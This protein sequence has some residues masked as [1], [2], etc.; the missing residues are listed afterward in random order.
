MP[1]TCLAVILGAATTATVRNTQAL[2]SVA[3]G[4]LGAA[5]EGAPAAAAVR[6][7]VAAA[8]IVLIA[9]WLLATTAAAVRDTEVRRAASPARAVLHRAAATTAVR[10]AKLRLVL[11]CRT[12]AAVHFTP[13]AAP[14]TLAVAAACVE[15][16]TPL[17][18]APLGLAVHAAEPSANV[19]S[20]AALHRAAPAAAVRC[21]QAFCAL[22]RLGAALGLAALAASVRFA[23]A[24]ALVELFAPAHLT[25]AAAAVRDTELEGT[26]SRFGAVR[27][28]AALPAAMRHAK[29]S[30]A[31]R[32]AR[33]A[34]HA[35][36]LASTVRLA[37]VENALR[38]LVAASGELAAT[39]A[40]VRLAQFGG[41]HSGAGAPVVL[42]AVAAPVGKAKVALA[43]RRLG[44]A[45]GVFATAATAVSDAKVPR[46]SPHR[47]PRAVRDPAAVAASVA[48]AEIG[49]ALR[50]VRAVVHNTPLAPTVSATEPTSYRVAGAAIL[51]APQAAAVGNADAE[52]TLRGLDA[53]FD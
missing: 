33:A 41:T 25:A 38:G 45:I 42:A 14:V 15:A 21:A 47:G 37:A 18:L 2:V 28:H 4:R 50:K 27:A 43:H 51:L 32:R 30:A 48:L 39:A 35:A 7:A 44:A 23:Q 20:R 24:A 11:R 36:A 12:S 16:L 53:A 6:L 8:S 13:P 46:E 19:S 5:L 52:R 9:A 26:L 10:D 3:V 34:F 1:C 31:A 17:D 22:R 29:G 49:R 40:P